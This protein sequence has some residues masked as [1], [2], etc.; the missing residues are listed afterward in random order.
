MESVGKLVDQAQ[1]E[2]DRVYTGFLKAQTAF[3]AERGRVGSAQQALSAAR[4]K[5]SVLEKEL[6]GLGES[7]VIHADSN[8]RSM[9]RYLTGELERLD[10][11]KPPRKPEDQVGLAARKAELR[12]Q[13]A[14]ATRALE[15]VERLRH[16]KM[17]PDDLESQARHLMRL[18][19]C[20]VADEEEA[21]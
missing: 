11:A 6:H 16:A 5:Q 9:V 15:S 20:H 7:S 14:D 10:N 21:L 12:Q 17:S 19:G 1:S 18:A 8:I 4:A 13:T 2:Y 3:N